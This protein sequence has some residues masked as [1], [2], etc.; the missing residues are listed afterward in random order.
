MLDIGKAELL[1]VFIILLLVVGPSELPRVMRSIFGMVRKVRSMASDFQHQMEEV[2]RESDLKEVQQ[3][4]NVVTGKGGQD[5]LLSELGVD[6][7]TLDALDQSQK[8]MQEEA[9]RPLDT[10]EKSAKNPKDS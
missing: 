8:Q 7:E 6:D 3:G 4:L 1:M 2:A 9:M 5:K 10:P